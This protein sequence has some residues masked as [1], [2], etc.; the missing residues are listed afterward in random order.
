MRTSDRISADWT[1][2]AYGSLRPG[3]K[4]A[5]LLAGM[6]G[7]WSKGWIVGVVRW[8]H[9]FPILVRVGRGKRIPVMI[10]RSRE[11]VDRWPLLDRFEGSAYRRMVIAVQSE[12]G[13]T[14]PAQCYLSRVAFEEPTVRPGPQIADDRNAANPL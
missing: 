10:F 7:R 8:R 1:L 12:H 9:G 3:E 11:L 13:A 2:A 5:R 6:P 4:N 14:V